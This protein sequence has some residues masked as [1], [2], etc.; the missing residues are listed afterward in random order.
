MCNCCGDKKKIVV[1]LK[2][3]NGL[4]VPTYANESD[5]AFDLISTTDVLVRPGETVLIKTG[6]FMAIP[7]GYELQIRSRSGI[8]RKTKLRVSNGVGTIDSG[9]RGEI[10][11]LLD[12]IKNP[13]YYIYTDIP[14][15][16]VTLQEVQSNILLTIGN[17]EILFN[18]GF[19]KG[20]YLIKAG[21][22]IAQGA[23][24]KVES[25]DFHVVDE[26]NETD[27]GIGGFGSTGTN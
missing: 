24:C 20:T 27:R 5:S 7:R 2:N 13:E 11:V 21:D 9:Y 26:L 10:G 23:I 22:R 1:E 14:N 16:I 3:V 4:Y 12:N 18:S 6:L 8:A 25:A 17:E 19:P 15:N